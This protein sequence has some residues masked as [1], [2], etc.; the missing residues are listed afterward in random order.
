MCSQPYERMFPDMVAFDLRQSPSQRALRASK[1]LFPLTTGCN[2]VWLR[3]H[4][5]FV[6]GAELLSLHS[7]PISTDVARVMKCGPSRMYNISNTGR[8][9]LVGNSMHGASIGKAF[10]IV[11]LYSKKT[12]SSTRDAGRAKASRNSDHL[13][14]RESCFVTRHTGGV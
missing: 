4:K 2:R 14:F 8:C 9:T 12:K 13:G 5:R 6:T 11:L 7:I 3:N 10:A 1:I